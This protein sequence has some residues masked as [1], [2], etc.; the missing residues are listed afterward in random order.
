MT[1]T[2][3]EDETGRA[4]SPD[5]CF[6]IP[7][8]ALGITHPAVGTYWRTI[9]HLRWSQMFWLGRERLRRR[10]GL[11]MRPGPGPVRFT[12]LPR[13]ATFPE[14]R[15]ADARRMIETGEFRFLNLTNDAAK[16]MFWSS[17]AMPRLWVYHLN[18]FDFV[19]IDLARPE[20]RHILRKASFLI[21]EWWEQNSTGAEVGWEPYPLSL[22]IVNW[23]KFLLRNI[24]SLNEIGEKVA[25]AEI[26]SSLGRQ[27]LMLERTLEFHLRANHL[28]KNIKALMFAGALLETKD[29]N[30][31]WTKGGDL[32]GSQLK[33]QILPD[34]GHFER[35]TMYHA[36]VLSD[37]LD[38]ENLASASCRHLEFASIL[39]ESI[40]R[41][42]D[43]LE[44]MLH[45]DGR[46]SLFN[47]SAFGVAHEPQELLSR[48]G[49]DCKA[50]S[51]AETGIRIL[52]HTGYAVIRE[53]ESG[54]CLV[55]DCGPVGPDDQPGHAH[56]DVL[57]YELSLDGQR[58]VVDTGVSAYEPG[59]ER[60]YERSTAAHNTVRIDGE[61]QAEIWAVFRVG[62][63]PKVSSIESGRVGG[64]RFV[65]GSHRGYRHLGVMHT[66]EIIGC[67]GNC[68]VVVDCL[69]GKGAHRLE[70][71]VHFHPGVRVES[72]SLFDHS[73]SSELRKQFV[74][75]SG[76]RRYFFLA[77]CQG[78]ISLKKAWHSPEFGWREKQE[79]IY[80]NWEGILPSQ[81]VYGFAPADQDFPRVSLQAGPNLIEIDNVRIPLS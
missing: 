2:L 54:S 16:R 49:R 30:R 24:G 68:W 17:K 58:V 41:M 69:D 21:T 39:S 35:S 80:W 70:S 53:P 19:N 29:S 20:D 1:S 8:F 40:R 72:C 3:I 48:A 56:C 4:A 67:P 7:E 47:D 10:K 38:L 78:T 62:R 15:A 55:F 44:A 13:T 46:I 61:E 71:F 60:Q 23:L 75:S 66:R 57:S 28:L 73:S 11:D 32:L 59:L 18:Y 5:E 27:V 26:L 6:T 9:R 14:W 36:E 45:P 42:A 74:I 64:F 81:F 65:R 76:D 79:V 37:L 52:P 34:G 51:E 77:S 33:E 31:W 50:F 63:R 25:V 22:R 12:S 43:F